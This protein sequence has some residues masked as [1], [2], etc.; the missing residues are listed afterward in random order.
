MNCKSPAGL[1]LAAFLVCA[2]PVC[3]QHGAG[4]HAGGGHGFGGHS[5]FGGGHSMGHSIGHSAGHTFGHFFGHH[6]GARGRGSPTGRAGSEVPPLA[7]AAMIR[8]RVVQLPNPQGVPVGPRPVFHR[9]PITEFGFPRHSGFFAFG[10]SSFFGFCGPSLGFSARRLFF[11]GD[12]DCFQDSFLFDPFFVA[13]FD[14]FILG[15]SGSSAPPAAVDLGT[16]AAEVQPPSAEPGDE[17]SSAA[18][19]QPFHQNSAPAAPNT[20]LQLANGSMYA[21]TSYWLDGDRIHYITS[22]GGENSVPITQ[23]D[24]ER[25]IQLNSAQGV[26]FELRPRPAASKP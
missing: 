14:P 3:A 1:S 23:I 21:L 24:F 8:G 22:Y 15:T 16:S 9:R 4:G 18:S 10:G 2:F 6:S 7:G 20:L 13:G 26:E 17:N 12:F 5:G 25:T 19:D 11:G